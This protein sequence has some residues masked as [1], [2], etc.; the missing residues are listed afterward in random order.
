MGQKFRLKTDGTILE[1]VSLFPEKSVA[2]PAG[3]KGI[4]VGERVEMVHG[5]TENI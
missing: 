5:K 1:I 3:S 4:D 2:R